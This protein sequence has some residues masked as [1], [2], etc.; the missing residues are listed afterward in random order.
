MAASSD[1][2]A[3]EACAAAGVNC[4]PAEVLTKMY[5]GDQIQIVARLGEEAEVVVREQRAEADPAL[6][7]VHPGDPITVSWDETATHV[8]ST[9]GPAVTP[10]EER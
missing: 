10:E 1:P 9:A 3:R 5:L 6:D 4:S 7:T 2:A 8:M